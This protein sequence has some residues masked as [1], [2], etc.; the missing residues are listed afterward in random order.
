MK[1]FKFPKRSKKTPTPT[2]SAS[3][4]L[5]ATAGIVGNA[6]HPLDIPSPQALPGSPPVTQSESDGKLL[7]GVT[8]KAENLGISILHEPADAVV[9]IVFVHGLTGN[10]FDTWFEKTSKKH[11]PTD[12]VKQDLPAARLLAFGYR[13]DVAN[14]WGPA[15][16]ASLSAHA[17]N[18]VGHLV[19]LREETDS[20][21]KLWPVPNDY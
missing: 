12:F 6:E 4:A 18:L 2:E 14:F 16:Q 13:T 20:V 1:R 11:W 9:D 5:A 17:S 3:T 21:L 10:A 8:A 19:D 15:S 7:Q